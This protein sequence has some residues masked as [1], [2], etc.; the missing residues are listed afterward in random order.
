MGE[1]LTVSCSGRIAVYL[2]S[3]KNKTG[4][5]AGPVALWLLPLPCTTGHEP[6]MWQSWK[7]A[8][9]NNQLSTYGTDGDVNAQGGQGTHLKT[10]RK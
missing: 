3:S 7:K 1:L 9:T 6:T 5:W 2:S 4:P 10:H 8:L